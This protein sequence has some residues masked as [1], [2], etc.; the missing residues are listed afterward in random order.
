MSSIGSMLT[1][2]DDSSSISDSNWWLCYI[3]L[4]LIPIVFVCVACFSVWRDRRT[5]TK[6]DVEAI[7]AIYSK[8]WTGPRDLTETK[9]PAGFPQTRPGLYVPTLGRDRAGPRTQNGFPAP[10][11][12]TLSSGYN[13]RSGG[14]AAAATAATTAATTEKR[15]HMAQMPPN[16]NLA[17]AASAG[18]SSYATRGVVVTEQRRVAGDGYWGNGGFKDV[19]I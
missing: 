7:N 18:P 10:A 5:R 17:A 19:L 2:R 1:A 6:Y 3:V 8:Y 16:R 14:A 9:R 4:A 15:S 12:N 13:S 11:P